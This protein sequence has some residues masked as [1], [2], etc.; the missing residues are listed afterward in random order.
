[1][2]QNIRTELH[3]KIDELFDGAA[4]DELAGDFDGHGKKMAKIAGIAEA[5]ASL[6][7]LAMYASI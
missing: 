6:W 7:K 5:L 1:M 3:L 2:L 4:V